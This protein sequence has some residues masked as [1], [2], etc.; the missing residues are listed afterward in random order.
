MT[1]EGCANQ[2]GKRAISGYII[3]VSLTA[4]RQDGK[5]IARSVR[6]SM[7]CGS[8]GGGGGDIFPSLDE[9]GQFALL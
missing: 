8:G 5:R 6:T 7:A 2:A 1:H 3:A 9:G 4:A